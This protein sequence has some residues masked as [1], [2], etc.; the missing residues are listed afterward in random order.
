MLHAHITSWA[1]ALILFIVT[2]VLLK[3]GNTKQA[4]VFSMILRVLYIAIIV[5]GI[6]L[7][8]DVMNVIKD[9]LY[10]LKMLFGLLT[11]GMLE[12][13]LVR[14]TKGKSTPVFWTL[15]VV[16]LGVT[17]YCGLALPLGWAPF[18]QA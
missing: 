7:Y 11:I 9:P 4:K 12:M 8:L 1:L 10:H 5:T 14:I 13:L 6:M 18:Y 15:L 2:F 16:A 3:N 17:V